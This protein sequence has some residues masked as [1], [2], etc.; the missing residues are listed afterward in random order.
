M[1]LFFENKMS[2]IIRLLYVSVDCFFLNFI[3]VLLGI[4]MFLDAVL[5]FAVN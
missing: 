1:S 3:L 2:F 5:L 4:C